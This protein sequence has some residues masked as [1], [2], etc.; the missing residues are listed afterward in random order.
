[1][2]K[3]LLA[4]GIILALAFSVTAATS[5]FNQTHETT[6]SSEKDGDCDKCGKKDCKG[7]DCKATKKC[8]K[9]ETKSCCKKGDSKKACTGKTEC[10]KGEAKKACAHKEAH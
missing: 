4:F 8:T 7:D 3:F 2:K 6:V 9:G 5:N 1:M 10:K